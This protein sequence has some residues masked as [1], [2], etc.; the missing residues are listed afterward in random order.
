M[1]ETLSNLFTLARLQK[2]LFTIYTTNVRMKR[3]KPE[4][5]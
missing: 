2:Y 4:F 5:T 3:T 1:K